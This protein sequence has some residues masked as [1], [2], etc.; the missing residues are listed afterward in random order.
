MAKKKD[1]YHASYTLNGLTDLAFGLATDKQVSS[2]ET[3]RLNNRTYLVSN[4]RP[5]LSYAYSTYGIIQTL[6]DQPIE[7][8]FK[9]G[10]QI[11]SE[12]LDDDDISDLQKFLQDEGVLN[13]I[14]DAMRW[15][16]LFGGSGIIINTVGKSDSPLRITQINKNTPLEIYAAD[17]WELNRSSTGSYTEEKPYIAGSGQHDFYY[18]GN[19]LDPS[20]VIAIKGKTAPSLL[21]PQLRG[22]GMSEVERVIISFNQFLKNNNV[23]FDLLDEAKVDVYGLKNFHQT[24]GTPEGTQ[25]VLKSIQ[26]MNQVK[27]YQ[28]AIIK[29]KDDDYE[30]KTQT[31]T[32]LA[33]VLREI[34]IAI[35]SDVKMPINK[36]FGQSASGFASGE[37]SIENYNSMIE[38]EI[39]GKNDNTIAK[40]VKLYAK[41]LFDT[42]VD[43]I[44]IGYN[45][46]RELN[47]EQE[48]NMNNVVINNILSMVDRGVITIE[49]ATQEI[50][51]RNILMTQING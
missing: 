1:N 16:R 30:Q 41:K 17:L 26:M 35:A 22:W 19:K 45:P 14:K 18:Y 38:A 24:I 32:G 28:N 5:T 27:S 44:K 11:K 42:E 48:A 20:R 50:N 21:R 6:I 15:E 33:E 40:I 31:F 36:L 4:D 12:M 8:C 47:S 46:L 3:L 10:I 37:D 9:G 34:R 39:R 2:T 25:K 23:I 13:T 7:D 51:K 43:D 49:E 29:D